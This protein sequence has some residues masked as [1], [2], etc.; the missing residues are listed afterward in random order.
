MK[1]LKQD[2]AQKQAEI[3]GEKAKGTFLST[4]ETLG[5]YYVS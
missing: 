5:K 1:I 4:A 3:A 2:L